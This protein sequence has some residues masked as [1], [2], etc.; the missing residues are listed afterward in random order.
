MSK[1]F[2][3]LLVTLAVVATVYLLLKKLFPKSAEAS[4]AKAVNTKRKLAISI[5][6][7]DKALA[8]KIA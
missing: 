5:K 7:L 1:F 8:K 4:N 3:Y 2:T 6:K